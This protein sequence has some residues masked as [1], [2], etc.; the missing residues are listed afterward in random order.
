MTVAPTEFEQMML[1]LINRARSDP[2]GELDHLILQDDPAIGAE[3]GITG[4]LRFFEVDIALLRSQLDGVAAV[5]PVAWNENL[6]TSADTHSQLMLDFD[7][8]SHNLPGELGLG[9]RI[10]DAGYQFRRAAENIFAFTESPV[11]GHAGFYIDWGFGPGGIQDPAGHRLAILSPNFTEVGLGVLEQ[12]DPNAN[13]GPFLV[14]QHFGQ[15][16]GTGPFLTG[17]VIDDLNDDDF[18]GFGE[19]L[20]G[21]SVE[22]VGIN[23]TT[24]TFSTVTYATGGYTLEVANGT[25]EDHLLGR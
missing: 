15:R 8:Q 7:Q 18:Y 25:Y 13:T 10:R 21:V 12:T 22:A 23:G 5:A 16:S 1:E 9:D 14:T 2:S 11:Q 24:G 17:V 6:A 19:G 4:A 20:G 3:G